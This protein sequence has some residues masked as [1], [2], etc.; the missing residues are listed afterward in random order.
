[1]EEDRSKYKEKQHFFGKDSAPGIWH[2]LDVVLLLSH[3]PQKT[4]NAFLTYIS[5]QKKWRKPNNLV[6]NLSVYR[7]LLQTLFIHKPDGARCEHKSKSIIKEDE[8]M[9]SSNFLPLEYVL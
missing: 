2:F 5:S 9:V 7:D 4:P 6:Q 3:A 8:D 1:M